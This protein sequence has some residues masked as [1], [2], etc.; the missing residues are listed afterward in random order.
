[1]SKAKLANNSP[2]IFGVVRNYINCDITRSFVG[3]EVHILVLVLQDI[4]AIDEI[5]KCRV[6]FLERPHFLGFMP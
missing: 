1:M 2:H 5:V 3:G 4:L 6:G